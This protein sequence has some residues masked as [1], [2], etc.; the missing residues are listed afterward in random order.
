M[1]S[2]VTQTSDETV[3]EYGIRVSKILKQ[4]VDAFEHQYSEKVAYGMVHAARAAG[5]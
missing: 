1:L 4:L 5:L 2:I 3:L